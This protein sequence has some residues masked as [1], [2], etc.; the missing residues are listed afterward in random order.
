MNPLSEKFQLLI[1][2]DL[3]GLRLDRALSQ[4]P[5][6]ESRSQATRLVDLGFVLFKGVAVKPARV[7]AVGE[8][9]D[10]EVPPKDKPELQPYDLKLEIYFEDEH[11]IV[12]NKP[13]G[14]VVHPAAGHAA[15]T[16]VNALL[17]HTNQLS[18]G[19]E[20]DRPGLVHRLDKDTSGLIV[21]AKSDSVH[22]ALATQFRKKMVHRIY[23]A[24][25]YGRWND[26]SGT[27]RSYLKRNPGDRKKFASVKEKT[28]GDPAGKLAITHYQVLKEHQAGISL[29]QLKLE[30]GRTHQIR[31]HTS[32]AGHGIVGDPIYGNHARYRQL[33]GQTLQ[34]QLKQAPHLMLHAMELGFLHPKTSQH[35]KFKA[36]WPT[37]THELLRFLDFPNGTEDAP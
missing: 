24:V 25:C 6:I 9:Y 7:T 30:T 16:L 5:K 8:I 12:V 23:R 37:E 34:Q 31:V 27:I 1:D 21:V 2:V 4:H 32:E 14:L 26:E 36:P 20:A 28:D 10:V 15:D 29:L 13:S 19:F 18:S 3:A 33:R 11:L 17:H 22:R 35:L